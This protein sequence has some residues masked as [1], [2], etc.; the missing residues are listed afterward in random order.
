MDERYEFKPSD[1][2]RFRHILVAY[3]PGGIVPLPLRMLA[4]ISIW[5]YCVLLSYR[6]GLVDAHR[7]LRS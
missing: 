4:R 3:S 7:V 1:L 6:D 2:N 5:I